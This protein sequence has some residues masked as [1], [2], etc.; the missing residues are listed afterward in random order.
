[1]KF[2]VKPVAF[3]VITLL[4]Q[5]C[6]VASFE[7]LLK[8]GGKLEERGDI[9]GMLRGA[10]ALSRSLLKSKEAEPMTKLAEAVAG[11][12]SSTP[13]TSLRKFQFKTSRFGGDST[14]LLMS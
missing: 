14:N 7:H 1:M 9:P 6:G 4:C 11:N 12:L 8:F 13:R 5:V 2:S 3:L 10:S